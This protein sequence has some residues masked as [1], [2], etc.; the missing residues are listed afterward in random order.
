MPVEFESAKLNVGL[1]QMILLRNFVRT[2]SLSCRDP[3]DRIRDLSREVTRM[4]SD[5]STDAINQVPTV[6]REVQSASSP[7]ASAHVYEALI[8]DAALRQSLVS[9][10]S[11]GSRGLAVAALDRADVPAFS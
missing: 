5:K 8:L 2:S 10:R 4:N 11:L 1:W 3:I 7:A 9:I 6:G